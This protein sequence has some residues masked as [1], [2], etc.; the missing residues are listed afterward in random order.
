MASPSIMSGSGSSSGNR[1]WKP[2]YEKR[3]RIAT[4][5]QQGIELIEHLHKKKREVDRLHLDVRRFSQVV[6]CDVEELVDQPFETGRAF[7]E[8]R[9]G[10]AVASLCGHIRDLV[11]A[12]RDSPRHEV[13]GRFEIVRQGRPT[14]SCL[15]GRPHRVAPARDRAGTAENSGFIFEAFG[16]RAGEKSDR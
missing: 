2:V 6:A 8:G 15:P 10:I 12:G 3:G 16:N 11:A 7:V 13:S 1:P 4:P 9:G 14:R 5:I